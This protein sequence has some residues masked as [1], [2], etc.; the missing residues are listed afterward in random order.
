MG[1][2]QKQM[3]LEVTGTYYTIHTLLL[4]SVD[5][6]LKQSGNFLKVF[7]TYFKVIFFLS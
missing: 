7:H 2:I 6:Q 4:N 1:N 5:T 3:Y